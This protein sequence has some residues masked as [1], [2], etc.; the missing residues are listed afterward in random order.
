M[1]AE[2]LL[3]FLPWSVAV[4]AVKGSGIA[5]NAR[6]GLPVLVT[7]LVSCGSTDVGFERDNSLIIVRM[8]T[9]S[10]SDILTKT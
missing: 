3:Q 5:G 6:S 9:L 7:L 10:T 1:D 4:A 2:L 8:C